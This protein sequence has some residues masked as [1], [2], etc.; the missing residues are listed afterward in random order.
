MISIDEIKKDER[1]FIDEGELEYLCNNTVIYKYKLQTIKL[2]KIRRWYKN[3]IFS[4]ENTEHYKYLNDTSEDVSVDRI[5]DY[6]NDKDNLI[7][8][9]KH[10]IQSYKD[11]NVEFENCNYDLKKGCIV[12]SQYNCILD[13]FHRCCILYNKYGPNYAVNV[14]KLYIKTSRRLLLVKPFFEIK[15]EFKIISKKIFNSGE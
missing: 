10:S 2:K 1:F 9:S 12:V 8:N 14:L 6:Y 4:I 11:L 7:D 15:N 5:R 3:E 13:G